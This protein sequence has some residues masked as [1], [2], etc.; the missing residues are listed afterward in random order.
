M[1]TLSSRH[2]A[3]LAIALTVVAALLRVHDLGTQPVWLDEAFS[4]LVIDRPS[5]LSVLSAESNPPLY[6]V[7]L[8][9]F[10]S[11]FGDSPD[12]LRALSSLF[13]VTA[14]TCVV[15][16]AA[17]AIGKRFA[18]GAG[19]F[20]AFSPYSLY[21]AQ[22]ARP[23]SLLILLLLLTLLACHHALRSRN[24]MA[25]IVFAGAVL[26]AGYTHYFTA[27]ALL[28]V[29]LYLA[30]RFVQKADERPILF[31]LFLALVV[32]AVACA[33]WALPTLLRQSTLD[34]HLWIADQWQFVD[35]TW[36]LPRSVLV[37]LLGSAHGLTPLFMKQ[38]TQLQQPALLTI[39]G[40]GAYSLALVSA[41]VSD[42]GG[43]RESTSRGTGVLLIAAVLL[44]LIVLFAV[45]FIKPLYVVA[46]YDAIAFPYLVVLSGWIVDR[47]RHLPPW[48]MR[49]GFFFGAVFLSC[50]LY[51]DWLYYEVGPVSQDY[52]A[53]R[54]ATL[55]DHTA[56]NGDAIVFA[57]MRGASVLYYLMRD[58]YHWDGRSCRAAERNVVYG[59]LILP[60]TDSDVPFAIGTPVTIPVTPDNAVADLE[61][62]VEKKV[63]TPATIWW[64]TPRNRERASTPINRHIQ[65]L[66]NR[67]GYALRSVSPELQRYDVQRYD[68]S[69]EAEID[70]RL[71]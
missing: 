71:R 21:Y 56:R 12:A 15:F 63:P 62:F 6:F 27:L 18:I 17:R 26:A 35:K 16:Y 54:T 52:D 68:A 23:Y 45:S 25:V 36:M 30:Y 24:R 7:L 69:V 48:A 49:V 57:G 11:I 4:A 28:P 42:S 2:F 10:C 33:A 51:E 19:L 38:W 50:L 41:F 60:Y 40:V 64:V 20:L 55:L 39:M 59:C 1:E 44:P 67:K 70:V 3:W 8:K 61:S 53:A 34:P 13:S 43:G 46:R 9:A 65:V 31:S 14:V 32:D 66:L 58:G 5:L 29:T 47:S 37:L 22:E